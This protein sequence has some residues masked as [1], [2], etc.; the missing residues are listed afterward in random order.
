MKRDLDNG[1]EI[2][3]LD[4]CNHRLRA[5]GVGILALS[6]VSAPILRPVN[7]AIHEGWVL[8]RTGAGQI[9]EAACASEPASF[10]IG[11]TDRLEH[12]GWSVV[13][14][15][16][17]VERSSIGDISDVPLRPWARSD[18]HHF[19]GLSIDTVSGRRLSQ[20][21]EGE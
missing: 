2:L 18:K 11:D 19:V 21:V 1:L 6:G 5:G 20:E 13:V 7:F 14:I 16:K 10:V 15:G 8:V 9:L 17:L 3:T 4:E 12:T